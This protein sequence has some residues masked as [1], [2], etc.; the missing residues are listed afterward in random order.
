[1]ILFDLKK[2]ETILKKGDYSNRFIFNYFLV[3][4]LILT[5]AFFVISQDYNSWLLFLDFSTGFL[6]TLLGLIYLYNLNEKGDKN[7]F[8][9]RYFVLGLIIST[10]VLLLLLIPLVAFVFLDELLFDFN[11]DTKGFWFHYTLTFVSTLL[12]YILL[13]RSFKRVANV[14]V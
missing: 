10:R 7:S 9:D 4:S 11:I 5:F 3:H 2:A 6:I 14:K 1:M 13:G 12:I 8:L